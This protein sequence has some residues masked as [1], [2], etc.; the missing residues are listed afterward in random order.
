[1]GLLDISGPFL[2]ETDGELKEDT[3]QISEYSALI[4]GSESRRNAVERSSRAPAGR[5]DSG[6][7]RLSDTI[8][9]RYL[10]RLGYC[11]L[12]F[13]NDPSVEKKLDEAMDL[14]GPMMI[15]AV[16]PD[17]EK[18]TY[19]LAVLDKE[20]NFCTRWLNRFTRS[21]S[22]VSSVFN[23]CSATLGAGALSLPYAFA[24]SGLGIGLILLIGAAFLS[25]YSI[26]LLIYCKTRTHLKSYEDLAV[27]CFSKRFALFV[28]VN[29]VLFC[30]GVLVAYIVAA[31]DIVHPIIILA[32]GNHFFLAKR[33]ILIL[34]FVTFVML[35]LSFYEKV[36]SLRFASMI[37][38]LSIVYLVFAV[39]IVSIMDLSLNGFPSLTT[40]EL[41]DFSWD[42]F[43]SI[44]IIMFAFTN[45]VNVF[46][47]YTELNRPCIRRMNR[48]VRHSTITT[49][50]LYTIIGSFGYLQNLNNTK[51]DI[52]ANYNLSQPII[53]IAQFAVG[54]TVAL[55]FPINVFPLR[56][57]V[58]IMFFPNSPPSKAKF[59]ILTT[60]LVSLATLLALFVP[61]ID[62]VFSLLGA[63]CSSFVCY[64]LPGLFFLRIA[65]SSLLSLEKLGALTLMIGGIVVGS[66]STFMSAKDLIHSFSKP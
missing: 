9:D 29:I 23:L 41:F 31:A 56:F 57:T 7:R 63:V 47:I 59:V 66:I 2:H 19:R 12:R 13:E 11:P 5:E 34:I 51:P 15:A 32:F 62:V 14:G 18:S 43:L 54:L 30:L 28:E 50:L 55:S 3:A 22:T 6:T 53:A 37:G 40:S 21:G 52:L 8:R 33:S 49:A 42:I 4:P 45:Q 60:V 58:E 20:A 24:K 39:A 61:Q 48:V 36:N 64:V 27:Y 16:Q 65:S 1:M 17:K 25:V 10:V 38:V 46:S 44:P 35:P 26:D